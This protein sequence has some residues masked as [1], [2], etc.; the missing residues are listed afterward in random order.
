MQVHFLV[1]KLKLP[2]YYYPVKYGKRKW[3]GVYAGNLVLEPCGPYSDFLYASNDFRAIF[4]GLTFEPFKSI[5]LSDSGLTGRKIYHFTGDTY[6][7]LHKDSAL[8]GDN[9]T[10]SFMDRGLIKALDKRI[11]DSLRYVMNAD[12]EKKYKVFERIDDEIPTSYTSVNYY[13]ELGI[14]YVKNICIGYKDISGLQKWEEFISPLELTDN[15]KWEYS[16][17]LE[18]QLI[19]SNIKEVHS[20]TFKVKSLESAKRYLLKNNLFGNFVDNKIQLDKAQA[21]GLI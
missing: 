7:Y 15:E 1:Y 2:V 11:M 5:S 20:I 10:I 14:E 3:G 8:C 12:T 16:N 6:I 17:L 19:K 9:I 18:F 13:N 21:F 4:L